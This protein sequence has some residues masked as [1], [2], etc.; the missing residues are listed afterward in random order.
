MDKDGNVLFGKEPS[1][2]ECENYNGPNLL[3]P[4]YSKKE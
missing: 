2:A 1:I 3:Q 4:L